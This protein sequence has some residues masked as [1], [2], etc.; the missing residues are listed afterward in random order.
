MHCGCSQISFF[1]L[2]LVGMLALSFLW[3]V[4]GLKLKFMGAGV[5]FIFFIWVVGPSKRWHVVNSGT[6]LIFNKIPVL[7]HSCFV[8]QIDIKMFCQTVGDA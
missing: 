2:C 1:F 4:C 5:K 3:V 8:Y 6:A 7:L